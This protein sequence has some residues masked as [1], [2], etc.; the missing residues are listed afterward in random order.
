[1]QQIQFFCFNNIFYLSVSFISK[2]LSCLNYKLLRISIYKVIHTFMILYLI[3]VIKCF[4]P[5]FVCINLLGLLRKGFCFTKVIGE[6][7]RLSGYL[8]D[9]S[10]KGPVFSTQMALKIAKIVSW[11]TAFFVKQYRGYASIVDFMCFNG[12][13][14]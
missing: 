2:Q 6:D 5:F 13:L 11:L 9:P 8:C 12:A 3:P 4:F 14:Q 1:M 10:S 7:L